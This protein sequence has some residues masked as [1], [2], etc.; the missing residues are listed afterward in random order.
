MKLLTT[1]EIV[2]IIVVLIVTA[3]FMLS[4][5]GL[6]LNPLDWFK[7][8]SVKN[9]FCSEIISRTNCQLQT[10]RFE[11]FP[12]NKDDYSSRIK[13]KDIGN[14]CTSKNPEDSASFGEICKYLGYDDFQQCLEKLC[15]CKFI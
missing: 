2:I 14:K 13:C 12:I 3:L 9:S 4:W 11:E 5:L 7:R 10:Y 1:I 15:G 8:E 6:G